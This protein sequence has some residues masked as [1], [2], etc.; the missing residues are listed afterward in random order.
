[1]CVFNIWRGGE[2]LTGLAAWVLDVVAFVARV[3]VSCTREGTFSFADLGAFEV[4]G[5]TLIL[6][7]WPAEVPED[8]VGTLVP[9]AG[10]MLRRK[11]K[12][13]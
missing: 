7:C 8:L 12:N 3:E 5:E 11:V 1:M 6:S 4:T 2:R 13:R 9:L 10:A